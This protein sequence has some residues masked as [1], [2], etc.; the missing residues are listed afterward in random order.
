MIVP[1]GLSRPSRSAASIIGRPMRSL[2]DPPGLSSLQLGQDQRLAFLGPE[3]AGDAGESDHGR[4]AH[5]VED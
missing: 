2:T 5:Q 1:P 3:F 4:V